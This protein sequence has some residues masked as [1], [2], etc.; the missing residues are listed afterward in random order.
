MG[1]WWGLAHRGGFVEFLDASLSGVA[2]VQGEDPDDQGL[3]S[4]DAEHA[5]ALIPT[6]KALSELPGRRRLG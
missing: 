1:R 5:D 3:D 6:G 2:A 4:P